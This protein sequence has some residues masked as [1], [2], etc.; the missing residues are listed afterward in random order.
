MI[1]DDALAEAQSIASQAEAKDKAI[2][3]TH[4]YLFIVAVPSDRALDQVAMWLQG[5]D[6]NDSV[7]LPFDRDAIPQV[8]ARLRELL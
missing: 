1:D 8:I 7:L 4:G 2:R 3:V 6:E 5:E